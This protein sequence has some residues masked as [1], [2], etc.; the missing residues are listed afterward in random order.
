MKRSETRNKKDN[1]MPTFE[2]FVLSAPYGFP[3][4]CLALNKILSDNEETTIIEEI[5]AESWNNIVNKIDHDTYQQQYQNEKKAIIYIIKSMKQSTPSPSI[6]NAANILASN[7]FLTKD[8]IEKIL[9]KIKELSA[10][11]TTD[12][13]QILKVRYRRLMIFP[14]LFFSSDFCLVN[15]SR[16]AK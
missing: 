3:N 12:I 9:I 5:V 6:S 1:N 13:K 10:T 16:V 2:Q 4:A 11:E 8:T 7:S 15:F 14:Y